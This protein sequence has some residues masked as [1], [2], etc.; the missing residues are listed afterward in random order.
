MIDALDHP[1]GGR[2]LR[3]RL[4]EGEAPS[5]KQLK[6]AR[7]S[8]KGPRGESR[9]FRVLSFPLMGGKVSDKR[10]RDTGRVDVLV[11]E[12]GEDGPSI[13]LQWEV[14]GS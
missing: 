5:V 11:E 9:D 13:D 4:L 8:A 10:I 2:I 6:G 7:L 14:T 1:H 3:L 12:E